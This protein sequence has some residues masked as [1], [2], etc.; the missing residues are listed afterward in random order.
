MKLKINEARVLI[1]LEHSD[2][3]LC[4]AGCMSGKMNMDYT[5]LVRTL[6]GMWDKKW[7]KKTVRVWGNKHYYELNKSAPLKE[8]KK[9]LEK[10]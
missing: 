2:G 9:L 8:A 7:I 5:Y 1:F 3:N 6:R 4:F 10:K